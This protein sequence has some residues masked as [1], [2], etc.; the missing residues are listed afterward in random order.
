MAK[1]KRTNGKPSKVINLAREL[2][3]PK[4]SLKTNKQ[5]PPK[6]EKNNE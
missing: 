1:E 6:K 4:S 3:T 5:E 2:P